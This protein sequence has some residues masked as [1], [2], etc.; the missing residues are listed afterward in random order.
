MPYFENGSGI[1]KVDL[2]SI[3]TKSRVEKCLEKSVR[4]A[5]NDDR[6][7]KMQRCLRNPED[8]I[9]ITDDSFSGVSISDTN[10]VQSLIEKE[11]HE[12]PTVVY[13]GQCLETENDVISGGFYGCCLAEVFLPNKRCHVSFHL[14]AEWNDM[15]NTGSYSLWTP[16]FFYRYLSES[17]KRHECNFEDLNIKIVVGIQIPPD[18]IKAS[19]LALGCKTE[20][21]NLYQL[22]IYNFSTMT[23]A[24]KQNIL[25]IGKKAEY[26]EQSEAPPGGKIVNATGGKEE[27]CIL[28]EE[29]NFLV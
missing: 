7:I 1:N 6:L 5:G 18:E 17:M 21:V 22:P 8:V 12:Q 29:A 28:D 25:I 16:G 2:V 27:F 9:R 19:F 14:P 4:I 11:T 23:S 13:S 24:D 26:L 3:S 15:N 20:N 10:D